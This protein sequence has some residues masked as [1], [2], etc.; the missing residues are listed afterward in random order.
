MARLLT[1]AVQSHVSDVMF[2]NYYYSVHV[3]VVE[4]H[5]LTDYNIFIVNLRTILNCINVVIHWSE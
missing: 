5:V 4:R 2:I 1:T 3:Y